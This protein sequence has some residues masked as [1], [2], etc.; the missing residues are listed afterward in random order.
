MYTTSFNLSRHHTGVHMCVCSLHIVSIFNAILYSTIREKYS[1]FCVTCLQAMIEEGAGLHKNLQV[2]VSHKEL[3]RDCLGPELAGKLERDGTNALKDAD[4]LMNDLKQRLL[5]LEEKTKQEDL[6][7]SLETQTVKLVTQDSAEMPSTPYTA[8]S[9]DLDWSKLKDIIVTPTTIG[10]HQTKEPDTSSVVQPS[11]PVLR[12]VSISVTTETRSELESPT[13]EQPLETLA[14]DAVQAKLLNDDLPAC[15]LAFAP[16]QESEVD[17]SVITVNIPITGKDECENCTE[18]A[19]KELKGKEKVQPAMSKEL[20]ACETP[21]ESTTCV[22]TCGSESVTDGVISAKNKMEKSAEEE[23]DMK[24]ECIL[25]TT[26]SVSTV[27]D[28]DSRDSKRNDEK[29]MVQ[30]SNALHGQVSVTGDEKS[31][32]K[33]DPAGQHMGTTMD[34]YQTKVKTADLPSATLAITSKLE[35]SVSEFVILESSSAIVEKENTWT[36][37]E[38]KGGEKMVQP[39]LSE[40]FPYSEILVEERPM[41]FH[42]SESPRT[43]VHE[44]TIYTGAL[45]LESVTEKIASEQTR[46]E[47]APEELVECLFPLNTPVSTAVH[48]EECREHSKKVQASEPLHREIPTSPTEETSGRTESPAAELATLEMVD[49]QSELETA[50][51][52]APT[53][54]VTKVTETAV[55][56]SCPAT[57]E[58]ESDGGID[59]IE[60][61]QSRGK[62]LQDSWGEKLNDEETIVEGLYKEMPGSEGLQTMSE[63]S[64]LR[65]DSG[66]LGSK[67]ETTAEDVLGKS[68]YIPGPKVLLE[69]DS[70]VSKKKVATLILDTDTVHIHSAEI[71]GSNDHDTARIVTAAAIGYDT[72]LSQ[73]LEILE[74]VIPIESDVTREHSN[75]SQDLVCSM[76]VTVSSKPCQLHATEQ[77]IN[78]P[79]QSPVLSAQTIETQY[80]EA[81]PTRAIAALSGNNEPNAVLAEREGSWAI[82]IGPQEAYSVREPFTLDQWTVDTDPTEILEQTEIHREL[83][84]DTIMAQTDASRSKCDEAEGVGAALEKGEKEFDKESVSDTVEAKDKPTPPATYGKEAYSLSLSSEVQ[85]EEVNAHA[86]PSSQHY[87][88]DDKILLN[89]E[90]QVPHAEVL[91][92]P[93]NRQHKDKLGSKRLSHN[94]DYQ[95]TPP[96]RIQKEM[97]DVRRIS[98]DLETQTITP[99]RRH[100]DE[101]DRTDDKAIEE[102]FVKPTPPIRQKASQTE[103]DIISVVAET[104]NLEETVVR[105]SPLNM[106]D[107]VSSEMASKIT[108]SPDLEQDTAVEEPLAK[109]TPP[110]RKKQSQAERYLISGVSEESEETLKKLTLPTRRKDIRNVSDIVSTEMVSRIFD[111]TDLEKTLIQE[112]NAIKGPLVKPTP[113]VRR[114]L[115]QT[116]SDIISVVSETPKIEEAFVKPTPS[117]RRK[118]SRN[119]NYIVSGEMASR[120]ADSSELEKTLTQETDIEEP[121]VKPTPPV[122]RKASQAEGGIISVVSETPKIEEAFVKPTPP[123]RRKD[124]RNINYIVSGEMASRIADSSELEKTLTQE[125]DIEEPLVKPTPP[126]RRKASQAEGGIISVVSETPKIE[127]TFVKPTPPTRRRDSINDSNTMSTESGN[128]ITRTPDLEKTVPQERAVEEAL[129]KPT[130]PVREKLTQTESD[131]ISVVSETPKMEEDLVKPSPPTSEKHINMSD[132]ITGENN[133]R[134]TDSSELEKTLKHETSSE[135]PLVKPTPPVRRKAS[136]VEYDIISVV[137]ATPKIEEPLVKPTTPVRRTAS[138][139]ESEIILGVS[140]SQETEETLVK[141]TLPTRTR[142]SRNVSDIV[143]IEEASR[144]SESTDL[145]NTPTQKAAVEETLI[146]P[147]PPVRQKTGQAENDIITVVSETPKIEEAFVKPKPPTRRRDSINVSGTVSTES[148]SIIAS[149][150]DLEKA[151]QQE[152]A[153]EEALVKPTPPVREKFIQIESDIISV[154]SETPKMEEALVKPSAPTRQKDGKNMRD[155]VSDEMAS[156]IADSSELEKTLK[157]VTAIEESLVKPTPPVGTKASQAEGNIISVVSETPKIEET[158]VKPT[159]PTRRRDIINVSGTVSTE[160]DNIITS[161]TDLEKTVPQETA[162]EEAIGKPTPPVREKLI[163]TESDIISVVSETPKMEEALVKPSV[164]TRQKDGRNMSDTVSSVMSSRIADSSELENTLT[165]ETAIEEPLVKPTPPVGTK[166]S[167]A[168]GD[169]IL[170]VSE[171][172]ETV[173]TLVKSTLPTI[174]RECRNVSDIVSIEMASRISESTDLENTPIQEATVEETLVKS[175][176]PMKRKVSQAEGNII[177]VVSETPKIEETFVEP[178]PPTKRRDSINVTGTV[179]TESDSIITSSIDLKKTV[180]KETDVEEALVKPTPPVREQLI[181]TE[182]DIISVVSETPKMEEALV[183][184]SPLT[185]QKD[186]KNMSD[187]VSGEMASRIADS[188]ELEKTLKQETA[189]E[190]PLV[191][192]TPPVGTKASQAEGNIIS[193]VSETPKIEETFVKPTPPT[194]RRDIIN[195]S[196]TV[197]TEIDNIIT[198][199]TDLEKTV[200]QETAVEEAIGKPTP[201]VR[202][203]LIQTESDIISVVSETPKMEEALVKPSVPTRQKDGR[204]MSDTVSSIMSSRIADS[205]ELENTL[206]QGTAIEETLVKPTPPVGT[207]ASQAEG[208]IISVVSET[209]KIEETFVKPTPPTRRRDIINVSGTVSTESDSIITSSTDLEKTVS[210]ETAVEEALVKPTTPLRR[211]DSPAESDIIL[212]VSE[213]QETEETL[214]KSTLPTRMTESRNLSDIVSIEMASRI[215][216]STNLPPTQ[217]AETIPISQ[218]QE[219]VVKPPPALKENYSKL[220]TEKLSETF[221][222]EFE[223]ALPKSP[224]PNGQKKDTTVNKIVSVKLEEL[225]IKLAPPSMHKEESEKVEVQQITQ[226]NEVWTQIE[227]I[228]FVP[229]QDIQQSE[230]GVQN[231][232]V[233]SIDGQ[234]QIT[235][236]EEPLGPTMRDIFTEIKK[237]SRIGPNSLLMETTPRED[238]LEILDTSVTDIEAQLNRLVFRILGCRNL[239]A[240]LNPTDMAKQVE[241]AECCRQSAQKQVSSMSKQDH[242]N[243]DISVVA[244]GSGYDPEAM[245]RL[246]CQWTAAL[247]DATGTVHSKEAQLQ[248]VID[249]SRQTQ[250]VKATLEKLAAELEALMISPAESSFVEEQRLRSFLRTM[251]QER[252]VL[253]EVIRTHSQLSSHL[254][255]PEEAAAQDQQRILQ[256]EWRSLER[257]TEKRLH[258]VCAYTKESFNLLQDLGDLKD[259]LDYLQKILVPLG[260]SPVVWHSKK[261]QEMIG[262]SADITAAQQWYFCLQQS[263]H[264]LS[265]GL[266]FKTEAFSIEQGL[267]AIKDQLDIIDEQVASSFP[268]SSNP[269]LEKIVKVIKDAL[270]WGK[271]AECDIQRKQKKVSLL[272]EEVHQQIKDLKKLQS[273]INSKHMQLEALTEEVTQFI[274]KLDKSDIPMVMSFLEILEGLSQLTAEKLTSAIGQMESS[275]QTRE[276]MS[277]QIADVDSWVLGHLQREALRREDYQSLNA[278]DLDRRIRQSQDTLVEAEK[279][280]AVTEALLMNSKDIASELSILDNSWLNEKITKLQEDIK[281]V[282]SYEQFRIQEIADLLQSLQSSQR[283]VCSLEEGLRQIMVDVRGCRFPITKDTLSAVEPFKHM[284]IDHKYQLEQV[285]PCAEDKRKELLCVITELHHTIKA[286]YIKAKNHEKFLSLRQCVEDLREN[287]EVQVPNTKNESI[288]KE[289]RYKTCQALL[290]HIPLIKRLCKETSDELEHISPDLYPSQLTAEQQRLR[291]NLENLNTWELAIKNNLLIMEWEILQGVHY[292]S[293]RRIVQ[294]FLNETNWVLEQMCKVEPTQEAV[295]KEIRKSINL[296]KNIEARMRVVDVLQSKKGR[297]EQRSEKSQYLMEMAKTALD[298]CDQRMDNL[299]SAKGLLKNYSIEVTSTIQ[300][301]Q[302][303]ESVLLPSLCSARSCSEQLKDMQQ[304]LSVLDTD[305]QTHVNQL[306]T[307]APFHL[308]FSKQRIEHLRAEILSHLL[309]RVSTL[310]AQAQLRLEALLRCVNCQKATRICYENLCQQVRDLETI[311]AECVSKKITSQKDYSEQL[312]K[313]KTLVEEV[314]TLPGQLEALREWCPVLG[315][316]ANRE[317]AVSALWGQVNRLQRCTKDLKAHLEQKGEEWISITNSME[318]ASVVLDE[319]MAELPEGGREKASR[320]EL[321]ELLQFWSDYQDKLDC[322]HR[323]LSA[324]E[325]RVARLL[326]VPAHVEQA[327]PIPLCQQLQ[328][329]QESYHSLKERSAKACKATRAEVEERERVHE[330]LQGIREWIIATVTFLS[331][332]EQSPSTKKLQGV[333]AELCTQK[334]VLQRVM[335]RLRMKYSDMYTLVPVE[336]EGPLQEVSHSLQ[337]VEEKVEDAVERCGPVHRLGAKMAEIMAGLE[338]VQSWL[339]HRSPNVP[340]AEKTLKRVWDEL[341]G[342]HSRLAAVEVELQ[343]VSEE[344]AWGLMESLAQTQQAHA[345]LAKQAEERTAFLNK[346]HRWLQ[347][348]QEMVQGAQSWITEAQMWLTAPCTYTTARCLYSHVN[349]LQLVLDDSAQIRQT[350]QGFDSVLREMASV[351][352]TSRLQHKLSDTDRRVADTQNSLLE[353]VSQLEHA[354]AEVDAMESELKVMEK[355]VLDLRSALTLKEGISQDKLKAVE[356]RIELMKNTVAEIQNCKAGLGLPEGVENS[357]TVF[358][359]AEL[360]LNQLLELEQLVLEDTIMVM[361]PPLGPCERAPLTV[362]PSIAEEDTQESSLDQGQTEIVHVRENVLTWPGAALM[363]VKESTVEQRLGWMNEE[364]SRSPDHTWVCAGPTPADVPVDSAQRERTDTDSKVAEG[365]CLPSGASTSEAVP[366]PPATVRTQS[367]PRDLVT[368]TLFVREPSKPPSSNQLKCVVS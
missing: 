196:G 352:D 333:H 314:D 48:T 115:T 49:H 19:V 54:L 218:F 217:E 229:T 288:D 214:V 132:T 268:K 292:P 266:N 120:I 77:G 140:E 11:E 157:Q 275:L 225:P 106:S 239:P 56:V 105:P 154:V 330:E 71:L 364:S 128:I 337:E 338:S 76:N 151:V 150:T 311:L 117:T 9:A 346:I 281:E 114:K 133:S 267:Q 79:L 210:Q 273:D 212:G 87:K 327:P 36:E 21:E 42:E 47:K 18:V 233:S 46:T 44:N 207:K 339:E 332:L 174:M 304:A 284:I 171:S 153:V 45:G 31:L 50:G 180:P 306:Q 279:Q 86:V 116:E 334:A 274:P 34:D 230:A 205:S 30:P 159:P 344:E 170:G 158:F 360:L 255:Q 69:G 177:S 90:A 257:S 232:S 271:Q 316:R 347:E 203:K 269:T 155:T 301:L 1:T 27:M 63:E 294:D 283:K 261:V 303:T 127:E 236:E 240:I 142:E 23:H 250:K 335:E 358:K 259:H 13:V 315:C 219:T 253:G 62:K 61:E 98:L 162:V 227:D 143:C 168:E 353:P 88:D 226:P 92:I 265:Q 195:V 84:A 340:E 8:T 193:V 317:D 357:L 5:D 119:M 362:F 4:T 249:Y 243:G 72:T 329:M 125:T 156:R 175:S 163:Q 262:L 320:E 118:D 167:Q 60:R 41:E 191:K 169:I 80:S 139:T 367:S 341:D 234:S 264:A 3:L 248:L 343:D 89:T 53:E 216:E 342:L 138:Q 208:N 287:V 147:T 188:S 100:I 277:E 67:I 295:E 190:E 59:K 58:G 160:I 286:L 111:S 194:R 319:V 14:M 308:Y 144:I 238:T 17:E 260:M 110:V 182:S 74:N 336:I 7:S 172:Q 15:V 83:V 285:N 20:P 244:N 324:L 122:R 136:Q 242:A 107:Q 325:L 109:P 108:G 104:Q 6:R 323:A 290:V 10:S 16:K 148:D 318:Q 368:E 187:T 307:L 200:P 354:A 95:P 300:F 52:A 296:R 202:E 126:V 146:K 211:K 215:S 94:L 121:L 322:Q 235:E 22:D 32:A 213:S 348:H 291:Q 102:P 55:Q 241:E 197:S 82:D 99:A 40:D 152:T 189:I 26:T 297:F 254:S 231:V 228:N 124:S 91:T 365:T 33:F 97:G 129:G 73:P 256:S 70:K 313:L 64:S 280:S 252:A 366:K 305:F 199:T 181:K 355:D 206:T 141:S 178:T 223:D 112:E 270:A 161:T 246:S 276:K 24:V 289:K 198:S 2:A 312:D 351:C 298:N 293:E 75:D 65:A 245:Q 81:S 35:T 186:G 101:E 12:E 278:E 66:V 176:P 51:V 37:K 263:S 29:A 38:Q 39:S 57:A 247:W 224:P 166:A 179:S 131:I 302:R 309:V 328:T 359:S 258:N 222:S 28:T 78:I 68:L 349:A 43:E 251:D 282:V 204:N 185:R 350:L 220:E 184:P 113:P 25:S 149:S 345:R 173:E 123:T 93:L 145:E 321:H 356:D 137:S 237:M 272:P 331:A 209:P 85:S 96:T 363:T 135:E 134:I 299:S 192:P 103:S 310:K 165:Q 221:S 164:P 130:P 201:P 326:G 183:K 361:E